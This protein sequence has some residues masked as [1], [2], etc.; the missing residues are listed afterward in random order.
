LIKSAWQFI[1]RQQ[2]SFRQ[3]HSASSP[4]YEKLKPL[5]L[6]DYRVENHSGKRSKWRRI[7]PDRLKRSPWPD[8]FKY[9]L[10]DPAFWFVE[11]RLIVRLRVQ[12]LTCSRPVFFDS[13][14]GWMHK[15][16]RPH[17]LPERLSLP[18]IPGPRPKRDKRLRRWC[19][20]ILKKLSC[21]CCQSSSSG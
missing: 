8:L 3:F 5:V 13:L 2:L 6:V 14:D 21:L 1:M 9:P 16:R 10:L 15:R 7:N 11:I 19:R 20:A 12:P 18:A 17:S 4:L